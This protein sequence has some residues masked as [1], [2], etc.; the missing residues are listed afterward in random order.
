M[1]IQSA[2]TL[3]APAYIN[4]PI[5]KE[6]AKILHTAVD[7]TDSPSKFSAAKFATTV[8]PFSNADRVAVCLVAYGDT[9]LEVR[10]VARAGLLF[11]D[12]LDTTLLDY[13]KTL[14]NLESIVVAFMK[15]AESSSGGASVPGAKY[16]GGLS[17]ESWTR[18][19]GISYGCSSKPQSFCGG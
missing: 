16:L 13:R 17:T 3:M 1:S 8:F 2:L 4:S 11:Q 15:K 10:E 6:I 18:G 9:R 7:R 5:S 14:P 12:P 19:I